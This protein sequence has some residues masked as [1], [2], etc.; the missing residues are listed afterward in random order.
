MPALMSKCRARRAVFGHLL[1]TAPV[2]ELVLLF[3]GSLSLTVALSS[4]RRH[5]WNDRLSCHRRSGWT[6]GTA[7]YCLLGVLGHGLLLVAKYLA[8][9]SIAGS[10]SCEGT[11]QS[12]AHVLLGGVRN[13]RM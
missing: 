11:S 3:A 10:H 8:V 1:H 2:Q 12:F 4:L 13:W 6:A 9:G 5:W 7:V